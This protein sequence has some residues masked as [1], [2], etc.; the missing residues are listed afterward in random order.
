MGSRGNYSDHRD[1]AD[2]GTSTPVAIKVSLLTTIIMVRD[3][4]DVVTPA[5]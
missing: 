5:G 3:R 4:C 2:P 1:R